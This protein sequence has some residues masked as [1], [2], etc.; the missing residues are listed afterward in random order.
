MGLELTGLDQVPHLAA[1]LK[2]LAFRLI[3]ILPRRRRS[4]S[5]QG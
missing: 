3:H 5:R 1:I 2:R 4:N